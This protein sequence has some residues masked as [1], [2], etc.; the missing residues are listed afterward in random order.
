[1]WCLWGKNIIYK[2]NEKNEI[3]KE[4][5]P[6]EGAVLMDSSQ[7]FPV[8]YKINQLILALLIVEYCLCNVHICVCTYIY[9]HMY[10]R[11]KDTLI[12]FRITIFFF[13]SP[14]TLKEN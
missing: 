2:L 7:V 6:Q 12:G 5:L 9:I 8:I 11:E 14:I 4:F 1:M 10:V 3:I 13:P